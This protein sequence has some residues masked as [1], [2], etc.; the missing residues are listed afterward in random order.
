MRN[1]IVTLLCAA[2]IGSLLVAMPLVSIHST[3]AGTRLPVTRN[4]QQQLSTSSS[5]AV[6]VQVVPSS[7]VPD[8]FTLE[9]NYPNPFNGGTIIQYSCA[10]DANVTLNIYNIL[11][12]KVKTLVSAPMPAGVHTVSW[13]G[14]DDHGGQVASGIYLYRLITGTFVQ[15]KK[16]VLVK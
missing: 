16:L 6:T 3:D 1:P 10:A 11:G 15:S 7:P 5:L 8:D 2:G 12:Q 14:R 4:H 13:D 9:Q